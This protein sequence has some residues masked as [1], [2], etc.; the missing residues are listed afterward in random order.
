MSLNGS[1]TDLNAGRT[2]TRSIWFDLL[3]SLLWIMIFWFL[4]V[5]VMRTIQN[6]D[7]IAKDTSRIRQYL[8]TLFLMGRVGSGEGG[9]R[10]ERHRPTRTE[11][12][13][14]L[15]DPL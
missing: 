12:D 10:P 3:I 2:S 9:D 6:I 7:Q 4:V 15:H 1:V 5:I 14:S 8:G 13:V 11:P